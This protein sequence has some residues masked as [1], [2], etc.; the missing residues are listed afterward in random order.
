MQIELT[1]EMNLH[2]GSEEVRFREVFESNDG[3]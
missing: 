1:C 3:L 2:A